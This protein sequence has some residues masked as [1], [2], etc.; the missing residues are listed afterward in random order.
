[1]ISDFSRYKKQIILKEVG[2]EG[3]K[4]LSEAKVLVAGAGGLGCPVISYLAAAG[5]GKIGIV[6]FDKIEISNLHRQVI[7]NES[8]IG[9]SKAVSAYENISGLNH[10]IEFEVHDLALNKI[11]GFEIISQY[12]IIADA[13][14]NFK[15]RY[16]I[17]DICVITEK[18]FVMGSINKFEGQ[19]AV[20]NYKDGPTYRCIYPET[21]NDAAAINCE[22][23]GVIGSVCGIV[24]TIMANEIIKIILGAGELMSG[25]IL[26]VNTLSSEFKKIKIGRNLNA[27]IKAFELK[28]K[29]A[30]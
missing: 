15:S 4:K 23:S 2:E 10:E 19:V 7:F 22:Q 25:E 6:D 13:T 20:L 17:N 1:M 18:P 21:P 11:N 3:Q 16:L 9:N 24:G 5:T 27:V 28:L 30:E 26:L 14:D 12:D 8:Q 29:E